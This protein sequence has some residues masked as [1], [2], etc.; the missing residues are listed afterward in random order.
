L[1]AARLGQLPLQAGR[2]FLRLLPC[3]SLGSDDLR[4]T[5][6]APRRRE[7]VNYFILDF[8]R[9]DRV[10]VFIDFRF[11]GIAIGIDLRD[12]IFDD[13]GIFRA[14]DFLLGYVNRIGDLAA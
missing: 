5:T 8:R 3:P 14:K 9:L 2:P 4:A 12:F 1:E 10:S 7:I 11:D 6:R 13:R